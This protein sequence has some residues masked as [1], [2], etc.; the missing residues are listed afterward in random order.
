MPNLFYYLKYQLSGF[1]CFGSCFKNKALFQN[2]SHEIRKYILHT[3]FIHLSIM[4]EINVWIYIYMFG[5]IWNIPISHEQNL[6]IE[7]LQSTL[8]LPH[9]HFLWCP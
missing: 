9:P 6:R 1:H 3:F 2:A 4:C 7:K 5:Y 8:H